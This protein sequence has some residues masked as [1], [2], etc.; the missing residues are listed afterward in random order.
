[1]DKKRISN[2]QQGI[3]NIQGKKTATLNIFSHKDA[4]AQRKH[5]FS[6]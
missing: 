2:I 5:S 4:K 6:R 3:S 1:M